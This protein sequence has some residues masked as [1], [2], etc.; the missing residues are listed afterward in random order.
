MDLSEGSTETESRMPAVVRCAFFF[1]AAF[2]LAGELESY[3]VLNIGPIVVETVMFMFVMVIGDLSNPNSIDYELD[4]AGWAK[5]ALFILLSVLPAFANHLVQERDS[6]RVFSCLLQNYHDPSLKDIGRTLVGVLVSVGIVCVLH[7]AMT[8]RRFEIRTDEDYSG[9]SVLISSTIAVVM[10]SVYLFLNHVN[11]EIV[12]CSDVNSVRLLLFSALG[13]LVVYLAAV[14]VFTRHV[15]V[16]ILIPV[17]RKMEAPASGTAIASKCFFLIFVFLMASVLA[18]YYWGYLLAN[19]LLL[20]LYALFGWYII[21]VIVRA[22]IHLK[23]YWVH[24]LL[25]LTVMLF[26]VGVGYMVGVSLIG[27]SDDELKEIQ[28]DEKTIEYL[29]RQ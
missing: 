28:L 21:S 25:V 9:L 13:Y 16:Y 8:L 6:S 5:V 10:L 17:I 4:R 14:V 1:L 2:L 27:R 23:R 7:T 24:I 20:L 15:S 22:L 18:I 12:S 26:A 11:D 19:P 29:K 3:Q